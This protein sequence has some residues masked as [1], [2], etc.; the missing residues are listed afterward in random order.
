MRYFAFPQ[1]RTAPVWKCLCHDFVAA[2]HSDSSRAG[3]CEVQYLLRMRQHQRAAQDFV[4]LCHSLSSTKEPSFWSTLQEP[5]WIARGPHSP[6]APMLLWL[7]W[8]PICKVAWVFLNLLD[9]SSRK[10]PSGLMWS[11]LRLARAKSEFSRVLTERLSN[12]R[13]LK[14]I[15]RTWNHLKGWTCLDSLEH[16]RI[17]IIVWSISFLQAW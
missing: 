11:W 2:S 1:D 7:H 17:Q 6:N 8:S 14:D 4:L 10:L 12:G 16:Y 5:W 3:S 13:A 15:K 9:C